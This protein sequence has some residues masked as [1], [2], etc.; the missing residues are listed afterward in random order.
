M[1]KQ[2]TSA[3]TIGFPPHLSLFAAIAAIAGLTMTADSGVVTFNKDDK[4]DGLITDQ[5]LL[6]AIGL[7]T[8]IPLMKLDP[9]HVPEVAAASSALTEALQDGKRHDLGMAGTL[10]EALSGTTAALAANNHVT[11]GAGDSAHVTDEQPTA[12]AQT[13]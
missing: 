2:T 10:A 7:T 3:K 8:A 12:H 9:K 13:Q 5:Q 6:Q 1:Q 4:K 11:N